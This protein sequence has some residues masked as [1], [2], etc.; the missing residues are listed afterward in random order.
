MQKQVLSV[1]WG[2]GLSNEISIIFINTLIISLKIHN[3]YLKIT[4]IKI[5]TKKKL[6]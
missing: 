4:R 2:N 1:H 6:Q 5:K 3:V